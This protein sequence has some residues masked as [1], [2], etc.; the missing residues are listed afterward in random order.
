MN[1]NA[2]DNTVHPQVVFN[3]CLR[4]TKN[5][6]I[7]LAEGSASIEIL[8]ETRKVIVA[9]SH[10]LGQSTFLDLVHDEDPEDE[11]D[12]M[13]EFYSDGEEVD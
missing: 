6:F 3:E 7:S 8:R 10:E 11:P 12:E 13:D 2:V 1:K 4:D 5:L 9:L